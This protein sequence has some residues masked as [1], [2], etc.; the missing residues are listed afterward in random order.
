LLEVF[1]QGWVLAQPLEIVERRVPCQLERRVF[2]RG[3][4][5]VAV[6]AEVLR[7]IGGAVVADIEAAFLMLE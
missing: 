2:R 7:G 4:E 1:G 5:L 6:L 3:W